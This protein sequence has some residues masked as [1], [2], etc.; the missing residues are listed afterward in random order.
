MGWYIQSNVNEGYPYCTEMPDTIIIGWHEPYPDIL[1]WIDPAINE[2]YPYCGAFPTT[3]TQGWSMDYPDMLWRIREGIN[4]GYPFIG[5]WFDDHITPGGGGDM[6]IGGE[7][8][9]YPSGFTYTNGNYVFNDMD[10][11][12]MDWSLGTNS[13]MSQIM[14]G[15]S[16][17]VFA[18][19][20][21][22][23]YSVLQNIASGGADP[24]NRIDADLIQKLYG[25][26]V[27]NGVVACKVFP[28]S[29]SELR[30]QRNT[31]AGQLIGGETDINLYGRW[32]IAYNA[33]KLLDPS[34]AYWFPTIT[35]EPKQAY[36]VESI[37][38]QLYLPMAGVFPLDI[39][40]AS[41]IDIT[42]YVSILEGTGEYVVYI[43]GQIY[44]AYKV[45]LASDVP[46]GAAQA[47]GSMQ[48]NFGN[49]VFT[50]LASAA[51]AVA[52]GLA[53]TLAGPAG[54]AAGASVGASLGNLVNAHFNVTAPQIGGIASSACYPYPRV[55]A[56][57]PKMHKDGYGYNEILGANRS[58][59]Y[60]HLKNC[61]GFVQC[62][63]YKC[64]V[65]VA[66]TDEKTE[67]ER[68]MSTG[69]FL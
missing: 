52:G 15:L 26:N 41:E 7:Q 18:L 39:R 9:N 45:Q 13:H 37:D 55:I 47:Q 65:I 17:K 20:S 40:G 38:Y 61:S 21:G 68:L 27:F 50:T 44:G 6:V 42:L 48:A 1:W 59:T 3:V 56:K 69:V 36:E 43:N 62:R 51:G 30:R 14:S 29:L 10:D 58:C 31:A 33:H 25:A 66:T 2:G 28:F 46:V 8:T 11:T 53:G 32:P 23:L 22:E 49:T 54:A 64:D 5:Y 19:D 67:I 63:E 4:E 35:I 57:I 24:E 16:N 12:D 34:G 60:E